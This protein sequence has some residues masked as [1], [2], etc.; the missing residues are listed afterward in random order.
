VIYLTPCI[1][2]AEASKQGYVTQTSNP[3]EIGACLTAR[4]DFALAPANPPCSYVPGDANGNDEFNG[5]DVIFCVN[6]FKGF[7][8]SPPDSCPCPTHGTLYASGDANGN[9]LF[10]GIDVAYAVNYLKGQGAAPRACPDCPP[11]NKQE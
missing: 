6:Y 11:L 7:G 3:F 5:L 8:N 4:V 9:C 1:Y 10:N 2:S